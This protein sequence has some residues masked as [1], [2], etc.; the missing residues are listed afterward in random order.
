MSKIKTRE[1]TSALRAEGLHTFLG[2]YRTYKAE[3]AMVDRAW[4][5]DTQEKYE[6]TIVNRIVPHLR[7]HD[8]TPIQDYSLEDFLHVIDELK[9]VGQNNDPQDYKPYDEA[10]LGQFLHI[11]KTVVKVASAH[12]SFPNVFE[13]AAAD[14]KVEKT[15]HIQRMKKLS[16]IPKSF[17]ISEYRK[18]LEYI[19]S[20]LDV[21]GEFSAIFMCACLGLR[22]G[23]ACGVS[24]SAVRE[25]E[26][27]PGHYYLQ[28]TQSTAIHSNQAKVALKTYNGY[29]NIP[30]PQLAVDVLFALREK[31]IRAIQKCS[32][33]I[34]TV[35]QMPIAYMGKREFVRCS[36][37]SATRQAQK[38]FEE[39]GMRKQIADI[40]E[41]LQ[42][43]RSMIEE[44]Q[45]EVDE[46]ALVES[47]PSFYALRRNWATMGAIMQLSPA[48]LTYLLGHVI[49]DHQLRRKDFLDERELFA[50][51][52]KLDRNPLL[53]PNCCSFPLT[54]QGNTTV[55]SS[56]YRQ[57]F[58]V[59]PE[60]SRVKLSVTAKEPSDPI[61]VAVSLSD[62]A[63]IHEEVG[64]QG[65]PFPHHFARTTD[66]LKAYHDAFQKDS[67]KDETAN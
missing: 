47:A 48:E 67:S 37:D 56:S 28:V 65:T 9:R 42:Q 4:N 43:D 16:L 46:F 8:H 36:A 55:Q 31:R 10:T 29:R 61:H 44:D 13:E 57:D 20:H 45:L 35:D 12:E 52:Q 19:L 30:L 40:T 32:G 39:L 38:M 6:S 60:A 24:F 41:Y 17:S 18:I 26:L 33:D 7:N 59:P 54:L 51:K 34:A 49:E 62:G 22:V 2:A 15:D 53:N 64:I 23:E 66:V 3:C 14:Q 5:N 58:T 27:F 21:R 25:M 63:S 1:P 50:I 11:M